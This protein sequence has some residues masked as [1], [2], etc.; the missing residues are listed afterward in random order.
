MRNQS[1]F[2]SIL[3]AG[4]SGALSLCALLLTLMLFARDAP[5]LS[6]EIFS[7]CVAVLPLGWLIG[8]IG[9]GAAALWNMDIKKPKFAALSAL[10]IAFGGAWL[11]HL[12]GGFLLQRFLVA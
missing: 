6:A 9:G 11:L 7:L 8:A 2:G 4:S 1:F 10:G 5:L 12:G 3:V